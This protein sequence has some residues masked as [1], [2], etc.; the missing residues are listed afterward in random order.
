MGSGA[1]SCFC[2]EL[3]FEPLRRPARP[4]AFRCNAQGAVE[5]DGLDERAR[6]DYLFART[7]V[8]RDFARPAIVAAVS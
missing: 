6:A 2:Y 5:L 3:R 1:T 4:L 8:G 7:L